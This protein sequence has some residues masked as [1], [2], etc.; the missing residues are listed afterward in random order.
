[1]AVN[2]KHA[3]WFYNTYKGEE[4]AIERKVWEDK[5]ESYRKIKGIG[6]F[7]GPALAARVASYVE[8]TYIESMYSWVTPAIAAAATLTCALPHEVLFKCNSYVSDS[9][10][11]LKNVAVLSFNAA[12]EASIMMVFSTLAQDYLRIPRW[13][14]YSTLGIA[15]TYF[16]ANL[17]LYASSWPETATAKVKDKTK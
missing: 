6:N 10:S 3:G 9:G 4:A 15:S 13:V 5:N 2:L 1:M 16:K 17:N 8:F 7:V 11:S 14:T 12:V